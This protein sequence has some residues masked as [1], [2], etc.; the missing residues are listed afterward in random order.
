MYLI[1]K[2]MKRIKSIVIL[3]LF[4]TVLFSQVEVEFVPFGGYMFG[5]S[6]KYVGGDKLKFDNGIN[7]IY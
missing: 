5:G 6:V 2:I 1:A 4:P 3:L 7:L